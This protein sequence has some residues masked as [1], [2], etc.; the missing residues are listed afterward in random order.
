[1][2]KRSRYVSFEKH[3]F[4]N[5]FKH[6]QQESVFLVGARESTSEFRFQAQAL[7]SETERLYTREKSKDIEDTQTKILFLEKER[8]KYALETSTSIESLLEHTEQN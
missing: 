2:S 6:F 1:M 5:L 7:E 3:Y 4:Q 8:E